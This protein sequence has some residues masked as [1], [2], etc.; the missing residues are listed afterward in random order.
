MILQVDLKIPPSKMLLATL[1]T[2]TYLV[3]SVNATVP[4]AR[5]HNIINFCQQ[6][7][8]AFP[9]VT[10]IIVMPVPAECHTI[11]VGKKSTPKVF[12]YEYQGKPSSHDMFWN[13]LQCDLESVAFPPLENGSAATNV[14]IGHVPSMLPLSLLPE[15][16]KLGSSFAADT[17]VPLFGLSGDDAMCFIP[18][19]FCLTITATDAVSSPWPGNVGVVMS[20][21]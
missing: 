15:V 3:Q 19:P 16:C 6:D 10:C 14:L 5:C 21:C 7:W 1:P 11:T 12:I 9:S 8:V 2:G 4:K 17:L 13:P 18:G 20:Q